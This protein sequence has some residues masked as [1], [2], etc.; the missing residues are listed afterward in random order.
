[1]PPE[2]QLDAART[3]AFTALVMMQL[4]NALNSRSARASAFH[5]LATNRWLWVSLSLAVVAQVAVVHLPVLQT[6]FGTVAL[7]WQHW[8][9]AVG[10]GASVLAIEEIIKAIQRARD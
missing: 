7:Q 9:L 8:L 5:H 6:A 2:L 10:A 3:T 4:F 1:M